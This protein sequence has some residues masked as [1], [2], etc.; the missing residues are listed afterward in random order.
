MNNNRCRAEITTAT[1]PFCFLGGL[2]A[3]AAPAADP[4][5]AR[6]AR[7]AKAHVSIVSCLSDVTQGHHNH[8]RLM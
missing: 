6:P 1:G 3:A 4:A 8:I 5:A 2:A 7:A